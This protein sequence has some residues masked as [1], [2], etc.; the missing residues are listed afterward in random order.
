MA[1]ASWRD[2]QVKDYLVPFIAAFLVCGAVFLGIDY[3][4]MNLQGLSLIFQP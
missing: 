3:A 2:W 1:P 4:L